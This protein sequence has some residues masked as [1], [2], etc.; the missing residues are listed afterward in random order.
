MVTSTF[1]RTTPIAGYATPRIFTPSVSPLS[2]GEDACKFAEN[3][4][5]IALMPWQ[6]WL[7]AHAL[8]L[9]TE[10]TDKTQPPPFRYRTIVVLVARQNG[11]TMVLCLRALAG[12]FLWREKMAIS[13]AQNRDVAF[14]PWRD[15]WLMIDDTEALTAK[16]LKVIHTNGKECIELRNGARWKVVAANQGGRGYSADI[17]LMDEVRLQKNDECWSAVEKTRSARRNSQLWA[18]SNAGDTESVVLNNLVQRGREIADDPERDL[19][20]GYFEWSAREDTDPSDMEA[21]Q[22]ANPALGHTIDPDTVRSEL[23]QDSPTTFLTERLCVR[24]THLGSWLP[25]GL[26]ESL[27]QPSAVLASDAKVTFAADASPSL[28]HAVIAVAAQGADGITHVELARDF[29]ASVGN[30][31]PVATARFLAQLLDGYPDAECVYD[32]HGPLAATLGDMAGA[33]YRCR[34]LEG[35]DVNRACERFYELAVSRKL[36]HRG[37]AMLTA[38]VGNAA[39]NKYGDAW[40]FQRRHAAGPINALIAAVMATHVARAPKPKTATWSAY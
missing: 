14:E 31:V 17:V 40:R 34:P 38:H 15:A 18:F 2:L 30:P 20:F 29:V 5:N 10:W 39:P 19:S 7:F 23:V 25:A 32:A 27:A 1:S 9:R 24:V 13:L 4:C 28:E 37:D 36:V 21:W 12:L 35:A 26:W 22:Q 8:E 11:K 33:G 16:T 3:V 6:S